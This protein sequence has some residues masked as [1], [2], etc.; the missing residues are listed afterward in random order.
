MNT[1]T[2]L[3]FTAP[4]EGPPWRAL[5]ILAVVVLALH[6]LVLKSSPNQFGPL[7]A[8]P[9]E[10]GQ[11]FQTRSIEAPPPPP[12]P[13]VAP[14]PT[15][16]PPVAQEPPVQPAP[17][18]V[19]P[20]PTEAPVPVEVAKP[21]PEPVPVQEAAEESSPAGSGFKTPDGADQTQVTTMAVPPS[22]RLEYKMTGSSKGLSYF[23]NAELGWQ[24][25]GG[26]YEASMRVSALFIGSRTLSSTG[27]VNVE[28][29]APTRFSDKSKSEQAAHFEADKGLITFSANTPPAPWL[30]GAQDRVSVFI[31]LGSILAGDPAKYAPDSTISIYTAGPR[32]AE[33]WTFLVGA[34]EKLALPIGEMATIKVTRQPRR[35]FDQKIEIWY[36]P[37]MGYMPVRNKI[38]QHNGDF[39]DQQL[40]AVEL[41]EKL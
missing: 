16:K 19:A 13:V 25:T 10:T 1:P 39:V 38:T 12:P 28:G 21:P 37:S 22:M 41:P 27:E 32:D 40:K 36:A 24:N 17:N 30:K 6:A 4:D 35:E 8:T 2:A 7:L 26:R 3:P 33:T 18:F 20:A 14:D 34:E 29:L 11:P 31:Q 5:T 23:A 9:S 15:P